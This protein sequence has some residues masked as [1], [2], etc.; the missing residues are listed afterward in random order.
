MAVK[1]VPEGYHSATPY[2][3]I[4]G[5]ARA[6][7]FYQKAF[8][9]VEK[10]R[11]PD[12]KTNRIGHAEILIGNSHIMMADEFPEMGYKSPRSLGGTPVSILLYV[13]DVDATV[14]RAVKLGAKIEKP[15]QNQFYG[16]RMGSIEDPFGHKWSIATHIEDVSPEE[17][18][19]RMAAFV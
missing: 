3:V 4:D 5:A 13:P 1:P 9:A 15:V 14:E 7:E 18:Q 8:G 2:L 6:I 11:M 12:P 10:F 17:M 19:R 16:D